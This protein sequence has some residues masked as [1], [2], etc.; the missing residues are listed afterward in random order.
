MV[1]SFWLPSGFFTRIIPIRRHG[2]VYRPNYEIV[3]SICDKEGRFVLAEFRWPTA[4]FRLVTVYAPNRNPERDSFFE[5]VRGQMDALVPTIICG[6]FNTV[7]DRRVDRRG[8]DPTSTGRESS[9][10]LHSLFQDIV[11]VDV[12]RKFHPATRSFSWTRP[13]WV[14]ASRIDLFRF[15][16]GMVSFSTLLRHCALSPLGP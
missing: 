11:A 6:D 2:S 5:Y 9:S 8:S 3:R 7:W 16:F 4:H 12:W 13:D 15:P 1:L 14:I 10:V